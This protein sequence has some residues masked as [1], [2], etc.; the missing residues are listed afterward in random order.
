MFPLAHSLYETKE[1]MVAVIF[2]VGAFYLY[3]RAKDRPEG[4]AEAAP[5]GD[6]WQDVILAPPPAAPTERRPHLSRV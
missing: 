1:T 3:R 4:P 2:A 6:L 5:E